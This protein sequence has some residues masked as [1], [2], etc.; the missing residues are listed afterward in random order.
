MV[1]LCTKMCASS[2]RSVGTCLDPQ[3]VIRDGQHRIR[4]NNPDNPRHHCR[5]GSCPYRGGA[6]STLHATQTSCQCN[7]DTKD[8]ALDEAY[9]EVHEM[10]GIEG[11]LIILRCA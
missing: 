6:T 7:E 5:G 10:Q 9:N 2:G 11:F 3:D 8:G 4:Y 1:R